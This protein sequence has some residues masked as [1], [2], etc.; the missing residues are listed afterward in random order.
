MVEAL[1]WMLLIFDL[2]AGSV[3][4]QLT[5]PKMDLRRLWRWHNW[6]S[7]GNQN[8]AAVTPCVESTVMQ[9]TEKIFVFSECR[10]NT[11]CW[12]S[13]CRPTLKINV[14]WAAL[15]NMPCKPRCHFGFLHLSL[16]ACWSGLSL[17]TDN[18][19]V[20]LVCVSTGLNH[21]QLFFC[22]PSSSLPRL[23]GKCRHFFNRLL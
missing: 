6:V 22:P 12:T 11:N 1:N 7:A 15:P 14:F 23:L 17:P 4:V 5:R 13:D 8:M 10:R 18:L 21:F 2:M 19:P 3:S 20:C 16:P 9:C